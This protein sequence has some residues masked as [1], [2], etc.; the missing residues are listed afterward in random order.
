MHQPTDRHVDPATAN[1]MS[2]E[3]HTGDVPAGTEVFFHRPGSTLLERII[4][5]PEGGVN[6]HLHPWEQAA[7]QTSWVIRGRV[8]TVEPL[9]RDARPTTK[10]QAKPLDGT[11]KEDHIARV[12]Q[13]RKEIADGAL[14]KVVLSSM[15]NV[16]AEGLDAMDIVRRLAMAHPDSFSWTL[17][18]PDIGTWFG[19][20]PEP[21]VE[22][23]WPHYRTACLAGTRMAHTG[24]VS[25]P[26][27]SKEQEEQ[28]LVTEGAMDAL[29]ASGC[30]D[31][32][33][34]DRQT[35]QYGPIEHLRT[36]IDFKATRPME[37][38]ISALHPT[39]AV[40]GTP[41]RAALDFIAR[42]ETHDR[43]Y[44]T[45]WVGLE[46]KEQVAY[47]VNLR[48]A[49]LRDG[50]LTAYAGGGITGASKPVAEW[51][52]TRN[53]LRAVLDPIVHWTE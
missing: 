38:V 33:A 22:G 39:P 18:H 5:D 12:E 27:T 23:R 24:A 17:R 7:D 36:W 49:R 50:V 11:L 13:A 32:V 28:A 45:G 53:K 20:S 21:L 26:W 44:Y 15:L 3:R 40:G 52:E 2:A 35:I 4:P 6:F 9:V 8:E 48:C 41:R 16:A 34:G 47:Y 31:L 19:S 51:H 43:A 37:D 25:D 30:E 1:I 29:R 10:V 42:T 14:R 46:E